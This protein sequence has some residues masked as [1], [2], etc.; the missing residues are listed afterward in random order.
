MIARRCTVYRVGRVRGQVGRGNRRCECYNP[1]NT[2]MLMS[3]AAVRR[4]CTAIPAAAD[5]VAGYHRFD[6]GCCRRDFGWDC[7]GSDVVARVL[8]V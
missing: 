1:S 4:I 2:P 6:A 3:C 5:R 8:G 7:N